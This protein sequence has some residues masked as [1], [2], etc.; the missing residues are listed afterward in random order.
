MRRNCCIFVASLVML[1]F[2]EC[3]TVQKTTSNDYT[4]MYDVVTEWNKTS[5][6]GDRENL[7]GYGEH[8]YNS[9]LLFF[10]REQPSSLDEF[11]YKWRPEVFGCDGYSIYFTCKLDDAKFDAFQTGL[12]NFEIKTEDW[13]IKPHK[14]EANFAHPAYILQWFD[15]GGKWELQ[16]YIMLDKENTTVV[17]VYA[18]GMFED[19]EKNSKYDVTP[20]KMEILDED[21]SIY[22][23]FSGGFDVKK[24]TADFSK[25]EYDISFLDYLK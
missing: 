2:S 12:E 6:K 16:E 14:D 21:F 8:L 4:Y 20:K 1:C 22:Q 5:F 18:H 19:V 3:R 10:P 11:Y 15:I 13:A 24:A 25:A 23:D 9:E 7:F 17:F